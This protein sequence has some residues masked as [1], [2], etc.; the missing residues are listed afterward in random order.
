LHAP[1]ARPFCQRAHNLSRVLKTKRRVWAD[2]SLS[3]P[4]SLPP[5][6]ASASVVL[7][8]ITCA[9]PCSFAGMFESGRGAEEHRFDFLSPPG[10]KA[11]CGLCLSVSLPTH[12]RTSPFHCNY[13]LPVIWTS[14]PFCLTALWLSISAPS[15]A[16]S[17]CSLGP[18]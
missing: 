15:S 11:V 5:N 2:W 12:T 7:G 8:R 9:E 13:D 18:G 4:P 16:W 10:G 14:L 3:S 1:C 17:L 6:W